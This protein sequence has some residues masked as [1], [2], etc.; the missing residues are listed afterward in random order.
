MK[1]FVATSEGQGL[2]YGDFFNSNEGDLVLF[3]SECDRD[4]NEI[5]GSC[6]CRRCMCGFESGSTT[7]FKVA[8]I[9][10][11]KEKYFEKFMA[12]QVEFGWA[13]EG[14]FEGVREFAEAEFEELIEL[15]NDFPVGLVLEKRGNTIQS[16]L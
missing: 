6:G 4:D 10:L 3:P 14:I 16:R 2:R 12:F 1:V 8:E 9:N 7:T 13:A 15:A 11:T 5:D